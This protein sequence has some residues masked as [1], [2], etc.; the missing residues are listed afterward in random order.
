MAFVITAELRKEYEE[1]IAKYPPY[2]NDAPEV[3][4]YDSDSDLNRSMSNMI[5]QMLKEY[6]DQNNTKNDE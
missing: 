6:N 2:P 3:N 1:H 4:C 5:I